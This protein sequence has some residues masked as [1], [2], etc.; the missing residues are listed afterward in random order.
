MILT[1]S[2]CKCRKT[3]VSVTLLFCV[4]A[5]SVVMKAAYTV[6]VD[7]KEIWQMKFVIKNYWEA[8]MDFH[9]AKL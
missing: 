5:C 4:E 3:R 9:V 6:K 2:T 1:T 8:W 7:G